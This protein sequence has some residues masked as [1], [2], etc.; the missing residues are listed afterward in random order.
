[1][2]IAAAAYTV[3]ESSQDESK[4]EATP[5]TQDSQSATHKDEQAI[6]G[7][8][9]SLSSTNFAQYISLPS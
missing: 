6:K 1:M 7:K 5:Q 2:D 4:V 9:N 3:T 8:L